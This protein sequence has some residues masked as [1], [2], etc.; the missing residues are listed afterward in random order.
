[1][2]MQVSS[3]YSA[4][5]DSVAGRDSAPA[6]TQIEDFEFTELLFVKSSRMGKRWLIFSCFFKVRASATVFMLDKARHV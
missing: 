5:H 2:L 3:P 6:H 1:M 4:Q